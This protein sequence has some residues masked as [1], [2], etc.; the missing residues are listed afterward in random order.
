MRRVVVLSDLHFG[1]E[2]AMLARRGVVEQLVGELEELGDIDMLVLL[3]DVWDLWR[4]DLATAAR[5]GEAF[6]QAMWDW[7]GFGEMVLVVGNHDYHLESYIEE[8]SLL[9]D[10]GW[11]KAAEDFFIFSG[12]ARACGKGLAGAGSSLRL[13][14]PL[15]SLEVSGKTVLFMHGHHLD[16][17]SPSFWW[18]KTSWMA[19]WVLG[20]S[21]PITMSD[22]DRLNRP[23]FELLTVTAQVPEL[24]TREYRFYHL[25][26]SLTRLL[27]FQSKW[28]ASPRRYTSVE[29]NRREARA[30]LG[31][32]LPGY[33]PDALVFGHT[34]REGFGRVRVGARRVLVANSG[35]WLEG[36]G[37]RQGGVYLVIEDGI[38]MHRLGGAESTISI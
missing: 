13:V 30:L 33:I 4:A 23:F 28:G 21:R 16:Y 37:E 15:L 5:A 3:G 20:S 27:R 10:M 25:L 7:K 11:E 38:R 2:G 24:V 26:R 17:F 18:A 34:H 29:K 14:Y 9:Q 22:I 32:L 1:L 35:C 12:D 31:N 6:F 36:N 19:R 8:R